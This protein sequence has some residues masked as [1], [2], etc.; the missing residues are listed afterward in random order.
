MNVCYV[1]W[2]YIDLAT[3]L[4]LLVPIYF[5]FLLYLTTPVGCCGVLGW[6]THE[7][8]FGSRKLSSFL[9]MYRVAI[10]Y[11]NKIS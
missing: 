6:F 9:F 2:A 11:K 1:Y 4:N 3:T 7:F 5:I 8:C 10:G